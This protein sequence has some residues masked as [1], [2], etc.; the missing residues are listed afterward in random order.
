MQPIESVSE[1][2][3]APR[4][5]TGQSS[6]LTSWKEI[7]QYLG[8]GVR[9]VQRWEQTCGLPIRRPDGK[10]KGIVLAVP[11]EIDAWL[12]SRC[13]PKGRNSESELDMLRKRVAEL[14]AENQAL[15]RELERRRLS[16]S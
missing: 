2:R 5:S 6:A 11:H 8:K 16:T 15:R 14:L 1:N 3:I 4:P 12:Q 10:V 7:A 9:T 13:T